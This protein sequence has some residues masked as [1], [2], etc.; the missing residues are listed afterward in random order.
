MVIHEES[1]VFEHTQ[2]AQVEHNAS[3]QHPAFITGSWYEQSAGETRCRGDENQEEETPVPPCVEHIAGGE[4]GEV[5]PAQMAL[6]SPIQQEDNGQEDKKGNRDERHGQRNSFM[7]RVT[8][9]T[10]LS[11][12][13]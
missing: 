6:Q 5:L 3:R 1:V 4:Q 11:V 2:D 8:S 9:S 7:I 12:I 13:A 10:S